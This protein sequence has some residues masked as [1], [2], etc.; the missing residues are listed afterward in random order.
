MD[1]QPSL[2]LVDDMSANLSLLSEL[3]KHDYRIKVAKS[4]GK[5]LTIANSADKPDLILLD[6]EMPE[7]DGY[8]VCR[9]LKNNADT[10]DIP[11]IFVT[12]RN[13][14]MD[15]ALGL[16]LGA[17][18]YITKPF[19]PEIIKM[20][21][22]NHIAL[23]LKSD[24][25]ES[26]ARIDGLTHIPNRR[27][28]NDSFA[29]TYRKSVREGKSIAVLMMD[30]D[31]F[32]LYNDH[33]G[34]G[35]GDECLIKVA[36]ALNAVLKRATDLVAR[37]GG[38]EFVVLLD[39]TDMQGMQVVAEQLRL[40]VEQLAIEHHY[41]LVQDT[42]TISIGAALKEGTTQLTAEAL[43]KCADDALYR[44]KQTGRNRVEACFAST[45]VV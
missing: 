6:I 30:V 8:E 37:Y 21:I 35:K 34:H 41:S 11:I 23:K 19:H 5:A 26:L 42:I 39:Q 44:A 4:G 40:A 14:V 22:K 45:C 16:N 20:R 33:Y 13:D 38:E 12:A 24:C 2:L 29:R 15:E 9:Q 10:K 7:M 43:L 27:Y 1:K 3:L 36:S 25:L 18:D 28:F 17:V 31:Y 32:K